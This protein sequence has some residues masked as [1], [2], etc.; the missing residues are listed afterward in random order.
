[1]RSIG[2]LLAAGPVGVGREVLAE[3][4]R[5]VRAL[6]RQR[7]VER[8]RNHHFHD[9]RRGDAVGA[10]IQVG[11]VHVGER[12]RH[13][14]ARRRGAAPPRAGRRSAAARTAPRSCGRWRR[15]T[16]SA[17]CARGN[18]AR[19][20]AASTSFRNRSFG[21]TLATIARAGDLAAVGQHDRAGP[22]PRHRRIAL[23]LDAQA[24]RLG[25]QRFADR[26][27]AADGMAPGAALAVHFAEAVV[28]QHVG[29][30]R[31]VGAGVVADHR[32]EA[33]R[34]LD[35][36]GLEPV[37]QP[38]GRAAREQP[39]QVALRFDGELFDPA[40]RNEK[41][42]KRSRT[43]PPTFGGVSSTASRSTSATRSSFAQ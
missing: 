24:P 17:P 29:R 4:A 41:A 16:C 22:H 13:D 19:A 37:L 36:L 6:R 40:T 43:P 8:A 12:R 39:E 15:R 32:V 21:L 28:Q 2:F 18:R 10:R 31:M 11:A 5:H 34:R 23:D 38:L 9:R 33:E 25:G 7:I 3:Q 20:V 14:D 26:A 30:A 42:Q 1:M 27:H 35:R